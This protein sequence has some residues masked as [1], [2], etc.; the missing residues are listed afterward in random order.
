MCVLLYIEKQQQNVRN[1]DGGK[2]MPLWSEELKRY[3]SFNFV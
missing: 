1:A 2:C 3:L